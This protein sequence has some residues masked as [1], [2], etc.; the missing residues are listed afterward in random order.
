MFVATSTTNG[1]TLVLSGT[2]QVE[3]VAIADANGVTTDT[4]AVH[5]NAAGVTSAL[6][7]FGNDGA[8]TI[9]GTAHADI[10]IGNSGNDLLNGNAGNDTLLGGAGSDNLQGGLGDDAIQL[11]DLLGEFGATELIDGGV[12]NADV[13]ELTGAS[14]SLDL[15]TIANNRILGIEIV[16]LFG[17]GNNTLALNVADLLALSTTSDLLRVDGD[18][19][20]TVNST[21]QNCAA[22]GVVT[23]GANEYNFYTNGAATLL[24][25]TDITQNI[26]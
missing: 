13:L 5:L 3:S 14:Q 18:A 12:G 25:D 4:A 2:V 6:A 22:G 9:T 26:S 10:L 15:T 20:D 11:A 16:D 19:G 24:M 21:G 8:N 1:A 17:T 7:I 23:I